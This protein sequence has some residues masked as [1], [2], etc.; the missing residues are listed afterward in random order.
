V[1]SGAAP[2]TVHR[3]EVAERPLP[4]G[5]RSSTSTHAVGIG[6]AIELAR[7]LG[8]LPSRLVVYAVEG[9]CFE[10]GAT[11]SGAVAAAVDRVAEVVLDEARQL[12]APAPARAP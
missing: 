4:A 10:A 12:A 7:A 1:R 8:R 9:Q 5:L 3:F 2:G 11:L 6:E